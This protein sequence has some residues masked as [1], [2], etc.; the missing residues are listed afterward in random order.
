MPTSSPFHSLKTTLEAALGDRDFDGEATAPRIRSNPRLLVVDDVADNRAVLARR[1]QRR[2]FE[3][4]EAEGGIAA[5][6]L[7]DSGSYDAVLLD[8]M[9]PDLSGLE[10]L[11]RIRLSRSPESL[12][13]IM[14]TA[15]AQSADIVEALELGAN[16][17]VSKPVEFAVALARVNA[18]VGRKRASEA[19]AMANVALMQS[20]AHL[21]NE[22]AG[23]R[24]SEAQTQY[25][26]HHDALTGLGNRLLFREELQ[27]GL[28]ERRGLEESLAILFVDLDGFKGVNDA[29]GHSVG[30]ALLRTLATRMLDNL[31]NSVRISRLAGD[32]FAILQMSRKQPQDAMSL[33]DQLLEL[34]AAPCCIETHDLMVSASIGIAVAG[35]E[36]PDIESLVKCA[37]LAKSRA[38]ADG[39]GAYR[40]FDPEMDAAAQALLLLQT[41]MRHALANGNFELHYQPIV[42][43][44]TG[45]VTAC[46]A[47]MRWKHAERGWISPSEFIPLAESTGLIVQMGEWALRKAC[48][49][50]AAWPAS[51]KVAVNLSAVQ[52]QNGKLVATVFS[53]LAASGLAPARLELEI[54]ESVLMDETERSAMILRQL[55]ELGVRISLDDFGTGFSSLS[56]LRSFPFDK[57]KIDQSFIHNLLEDD[58]SRTIV[59]AIA[60]LG[61]SFGMTTTAEGVE[62]QEQM[63]SVIAKGCTEVQ[64]FIY[65][66]AVPGSEMLSLI[67]SINARIAGEGGNCTEPLG[68]SDPISVPAS[69]F[70]PSPPDPAF[71]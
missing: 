1:F 63:T 56:Y 53:A 48:A 12:P 60:G 9:M 41:E 16:D 27:R 61:L 21:R 15:N 31:G 8:V 19:L 68:G 55:R 30:D 57:I 40:V 69:N 33:A 24:R 67:G 54:T 42:S 14:V 29:Y 22:I 11:R 58:R 70:A 18:Q 2:N 5:L 46:E 20:N 4:V 36:L 45:A 37:D 25:L 28:S 7:I 39:G 43:T 51:V 49:D 66:R 65:S 10:V 3:I 64:G 71:G 59:S 52:F 47:L 17:Y 35:S 38:K 26:A 6:E 44:R 62:T 13:V 50:A 23:R 34:I 32:E